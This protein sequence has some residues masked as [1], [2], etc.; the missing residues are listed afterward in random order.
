MSDEN[1]QKDNVQQMKGPRTKESLRKA[2]EG[3]LTE[4]RLKEFKGKLKTMLVERDAA[5]KVLDAKEEQIDALA[6]E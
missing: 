3:E 1:E 6:E 4:A 2:V 5:R